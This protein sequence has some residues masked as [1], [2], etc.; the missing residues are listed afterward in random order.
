MPE[1]TVS[2]ERNKNQQFTI[3]IQGRKSENQVYF[4][5]Q[6]LLLAT[7]PIFE[8]LQAH[9]QGCPNHHQQILQSFHSPGA[10]LGWM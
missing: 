8:I 3:D 9:E 1:I 10:I 5:P 2:L 6:E 4:H 7:S